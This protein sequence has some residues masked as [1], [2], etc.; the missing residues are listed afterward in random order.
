MATVAEEWRQKRWF[1]LFGA[2]IAL[3]SAMLLL[4]GAILVLYIGA[5]GLA[6]REQPSLTLSAAS[7]DDEG[8]TVVT[9]SAG[10]P[11]L[12]SREKMLLRV[13]SLQTNDAGQEA[14]RACNT[15]N[16]APAEGSSLLHWTE[17]GPTRA[18]TA[19]NTVKV[20]VSV[21]DFPLVCAYV[22][23]FDRNPRTAEDDRRAWGLIK[24]NTA[25]TS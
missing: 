21:E 8:Y 12:S 4:A 13:A 9:V 3:L 2:V 15:P 22:A 7:S 19:Q 18:G 24:T 11:S 16:L 6:E 20:R 5:T 14:E 25:P 23:L 17:T 10:A 1:A